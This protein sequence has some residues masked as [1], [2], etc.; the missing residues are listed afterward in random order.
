M[1]LVKIEPFITDNVANFTF[2]GLTI[3]ANASLGN[4]NLGNLASANFASISSNLNT[5]NANL[6]NAA[7]ANFFIG[8]GYY[9][10][11]LSAGSNL[12][13]GN[14]NINITGNGNIAV[15][16]GGTAN[17]AVFTTSGINATH[18]IGEAGNLSNITAANV[19]GTVA[20][21]NYSA[22]AGVVTA[23]A[24][25]NITSLGLLANLSVMGNASIIGNANVV[26]NINLNGTGNAILGN[27][28]TANYFTGTLTTSAQPN[29]TSVGT[30]TA[31]T[32]SG[33]TVISGNLTVTGNT[34]YVNSNV[35]D[36]QD[37]IIQLGTGANGASLASNLGVD[38]GTVYNFY[39]TS[40][41]TAFMGWKTANADFEFVSN[42][43]VNSNNVITVN[44]LGNIRAGNANLGNSVTSN[45]FIGS[46]NNLSNIQGGNVTGQ[47]G[48]ALLAGTVYTN[49]QPN[50]TS[51]G[52]LSSLAVTGNISSGNANLG[53]LVVA[54]Y[55]TGT[56]TTNSQ[57]NITSVGTLSALSVTAN[58]TTGNVGGANTI[59]SNYFTGVLTTAG[60]PNIT[61]VGTLSSLAVSGNITA[62]N[63]TGANLISANYF[64]GNGSLLTGIVGANVTGT[65]A[66]A[67]YAAYAGNIT[68]NA[69]P[70]IT[71][72][73]TLA[74]L[75]VSNTSGNVFFGYDSSNLSMGAFAGNVNNYIQ[76]TLYNANTGNQA[77]SDF[78]IYDTNG[79]ASSS[80][81]FIDIGIAGNNY[82]NTSWTISGPSDTYVYAGNTNL[83]IGTQ[84][85]SSNI[86]LF[87]G[88]TLSTNEIARVTS[89]GIGIGQTNPSYKLDVT[90][91]A[92][93]T[94]NV[95]TS[96]VTANGTIN[97]T[98][99]SNVSLGSNANVKLTGGSSGQ[100]LQTDGSGNLSWATVSG[101]GGGTVAG[102]NT[103]IQFNNANSFGASANLTFNN[104]TNTLT[105]TNLTVS[106]KTNL[107]A[108]GNITITGGAANQMLI[109]NGSGNLS[110]TTPT[111]TA[112]AV[113]TFTGDGSTVNFTLS[114]TPSSVNQTVVNYQGAFQLRSSYSLS[115]NVITF[116]SAP[117]SGSTIEVTTT[118]GVTPGQGSFVNRSYMGDGSTTT[119]TVTNTATATSLIVTENGVVQTPTTDYTVSS[120]TLTFTSAPTSNMAIQIRELNAFT[121]ASSFTLGNWTTA[122]RPSP[123][124]NGMMGYN[125]TNNKIEAY[126]NGAWG[127]I[128]LS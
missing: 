1:S 47:V 91:S 93:I 65:T 53:N 83:A 104:S 102:S 35:T 85:S 58:I 48:N 94:A 3:T 121:P 55:V 52:T 17:V 57:P 6:G 43:T 82:S 111:F 31:L 39:N 22:Y 78:A 98:T 107:G 33:N 115:G 45:Y 77:S 51:L 37:P 32:V 92:R 54:N 112:I 99:A 38:I 116:G 40:A 124:A 44:T 110:W 29:I 26:G 117:A 23:N 120:G 59:T 96:N 64:S 76:V 46:G 5:G 71:R 128:T 56:L 27:L 118:Q 123:A 81:N 114:T 34:T 113:D 89:N 9:L 41:Q 60:Q 103:Q 10:T 12:V 25:P 86:I 108:V 14:S 84:G 20:N 80:N 109:T 21:A 75:T 69:Q 7:T 122:N 74:N 97:F 100:Y 8:N 87:A 70:N 105:T 63:L 88:G 2:G 61:S 42:A 62:G 18:Y 50:I 24:Q 95:L 19:T 127:N 16:V 90:G 67:N 11:G 68:V 30:L 72:V 79:P 73:G 101:S 126:A 106:A 4:A 66:N 36:L 15:S 119:F 49:A 125:T 28:V 13:N